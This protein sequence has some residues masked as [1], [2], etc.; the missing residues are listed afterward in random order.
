MSAPRLDPTPSELQAVLVVL[1]GVKRTPRGWVARCPAH[2]D[3]EPSLEVAVGTTQPW[4]A[5]C[6]AGCAQDV[7]VA[8]IRQRQGGGAH[9]SSPR[10]GVIDGAARGAPEATYPYQD[11][12]GNV[13]AEKRRYA[14]ATRG[15]TFSWYTP[16][17]TGGWRVGLHGLR[18]PLYNLPA[19]R[20]AVAI[21]RTILIVE[22]E[23]D[24]HTARQLGYVATSVRGGAGERPRADDVEHLRGADVVIIPDADTPGWNH[25]LQWATDLRDVARRVRLIRTLPGLTPGEGGDLSDWRAAG[26]T[27][28]GLDELVALAPDAPEAMDALGVSVSPE[29]SAPAAPPVRVLVLPTLAQLMQDPAMMREPEWV[30]RDLVE[31]G[32]VSILAGKPKAGKS[33]I[34]SQIAGAVSRGVDWLTGEPTALGAARVLWICRDE[35]TRRFVQRA[36]YIDG[37]PEQFVVYRREDPQPSIAMLAE[38]LR[39]H[40]PALVVLDTL[41]ALSSQSQVDLKDPLEVESFFRPLVEVVQA[42]RAGGLFLFHT[43]HHANRPAGSF[44]WSA[45]PD[46]ILSFYPSGRR[47]ANGEAEEDDEAPAESQRILKAEGRSFAA[48]KLRLS[49]ISGR[50]VR[51]IAQAPLRERI[52][53]ALNRA[54]ASI[55]ALAAALGVRPAAVT[56]EMHQLET[57]G[58]VCWTGSSRRDRRGRWMLTASGVRLLEHAGASHGG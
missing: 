46:N 10:L 42:T 28:A 33:T 13:V 23:K 27:T 16:D 7:V 21:G 43:P 50:Y 25:G 26:G 35:P 54:P 1:E 22:G 15:K 55:S 11:L 9:T 53:R 20:E 52:L 30:V 14:H 44:Q 39:L 41:S 12:D 37:D 32:T 29:P 36:G 56:D 40:E 38:L 17:G 24:V 5:R 18:A 34:A 49:F 6:R 47:D 57:L 8:A 4:V 48:Y 45:I 2:D 19:V 51:G 58:A 3:H 31:A